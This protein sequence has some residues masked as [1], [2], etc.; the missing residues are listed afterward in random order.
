MGHPQP[1]NP[2]HCDNATA[3]GIANNTVKR[4]RSRSMEMRFF[5]IGDKIAQEM[6]DVSWHPGQENLAD[7]QSKHHNGAHHRAVRPWYLHQEDSPQYLPRAV[8]PSALKGCVGT[9]K[10][11]YIRKVPLPRVPQIQQSTSVQHV[12]ASVVPATRISS[13]T[14]YLQV[15]RVPTWSDLVRSLSGLGRRSLRPFSPVWLM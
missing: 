10:D 1:K 5:W 14:C 2:V 6:Y 7:Y 3:V 8:S 13:D 15:P 11:G 4:Q 12:V 9:L